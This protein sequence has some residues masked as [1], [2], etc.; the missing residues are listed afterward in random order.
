MAYLQ[1][2]PGGATGISDAQGGPRMDA[3]GES[4]FVRGCYGHA[5]AISS[6]RR[7][8]CG[9]A[10]P[11]FTDTVQWPCLLAIRRGRGDAGLSAR[12]RGFCTRC[13]QARIHDSCNDVLNETITNNT[14]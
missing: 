11:L 5:L 7:S 12:A 9:D 14:W 2:R 3:A 8:P 6:F 4:G 10:V 13:R 1:I